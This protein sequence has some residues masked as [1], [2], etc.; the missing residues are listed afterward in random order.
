MET[1]PPL[2]P[3]SKLLTQWGPQWVTEI[4]LNVWDCLTDSLANLNL[5][6]VC[7]AAVAVQLSTSYCGTKIDLVIALS[8][9]E[10]KLFS[11]QV[12][13][14][15]LVIFFLL[16]VFGLPLGKPQTSRFTNF[17]LKLWTVETNHGF[18][19]NHLCQSRRCLQLRARSPMR[20]TSEIPLLVEPGSPG[21]PQLLPGPITLVEMG[22]STVTN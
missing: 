7:W 16:P 22:T 2:H 13:L 17:S 6:V 11:S 10:A 12:P 8:R 19:S 20:L 18:W 14:T 9:Q 3:E 21:M 4:S 5:D 15:N 1:F